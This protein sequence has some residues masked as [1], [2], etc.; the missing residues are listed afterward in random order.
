MEGLI[1]AAQL[2][3]SLAILVT[4]HELGHFLAARAFGIRV[5]KFFLFFDAWGKKIISFKKGD[6]EYGIGWLPLGG[7]VKISGMIDES[8]D[9]EQLKTAPE[10]WEFRSKPAW[11][12]F[13]VMIGGIVVNLILGYVIFAG[14]L[15]K[16]EK[17]YISREVIN[18][19]GI[20]AGSIAR[21]IGLQNGDKLISLNGNSYDRFQDFASLEAFFGGELVV[22]RD[23]QEQTIEVPGDFFK[24]LK[25][26]KSAFIEPYSS[27][28]VNAI[29]DLVPYA[30]EA[31]MKS[32]DRIVCLN[33]TSV[34][35]FG[36]LQELL[37]K[38]RGGEVAL[39]VERGGEELILKSQVDSLGR[40][41][42]EADV[43]RYEGKETVYSLG[44][45]LHY[46]FKDSWDVLY[47]NVVG[48]GKIFSGEIKAQESVQSIVGIAT[49]YGGIWD[50]GRFWRLTAMIS[51]V[52]AFMNALP[53]P[54][55]DGGHMM[56]LVIEMVTG[57][58]PSDR[59][60]II[61]QYIG[62]IL[63]LTLMVLTIGNDIWRIISK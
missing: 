39:T 25:R 53:I 60:L 26:N 7:Y 3:L 13:I 1:M 15:L 12:R 14:Y 45:A 44:Q 38:H 54:A 55:L 59:V 61:A 23:G 33:D 52:L 29:S 18:S 19:D 5:E 9:K 48:F 4:F 57:R 16:F 50:W 41:G 10:S 46:A 28:Y 40:L 27:V 58:P 62:M 56:F 36:H 32:G 22:Q 47:Y 37:W 49:L 21:E 20:Y 42:F 11:Q 24:V 31:G 43:R 30:A 8:L 6:T 51:L 17:S 2:I 63:L 34:V 35:A